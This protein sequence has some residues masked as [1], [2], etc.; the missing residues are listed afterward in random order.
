M[1]PRP[2]PGHH[3]HHQ[4]TQEDSL[5]LLQPHRSLHPHSQHGCSRLHPSPG[6]RGETVPRCVYYVIYNKSSLQGSHRQNKKIFHNFQK[7][8]PVI[9]SYYSHQS[10]TVSKTFGN[11]VAKFKL[12]T[13]FNCGN[14]MISQDHISDLTKNRNLEQ[15][16]R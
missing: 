1:L 16:R 4:D 10:S 13:F 5:L 11:K 7:L 8:F 15:C 9:N 3:L 12:V 14:V 2:L 6:L